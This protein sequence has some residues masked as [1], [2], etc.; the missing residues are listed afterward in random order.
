MD[1]VG[2][3]QQKLIYLHTHWG[4]RYEFAAPEQPS[5]KW[6]ATARFGNHDGL[7]ASSAAELLEDVRA[8]Y[9]A[10]APTETSRDER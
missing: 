8:H 2:T 6:A 7:E 3:V 10:S 1:I 5:G 9:R 4:R